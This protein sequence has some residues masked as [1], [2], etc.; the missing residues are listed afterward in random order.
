MSNH[1]STN[2]W[3]E[4][5][6]TAL[7]KLEL[8]LAE[9][10]MKDITVLDVGPGGIAQRYASQIPS[11]D[12]YDMDIIARARKNTVNWPESIARDK[13]SSEL[14]SFEPREIY[15]LFSE[16]IGIREMIV[17]DREKRVIDAVNNMN[18]SHTRTLLRDIEDTNPHDMQADVVIGLVLIEYCKKN[19]IQARRSLYDSVK[20]GGF[21]LVNLP[22]NIP[23]YIPGFTQINV[24][25]RKPLRDIEDPRKIYVKRE[26]SANPTHI[27]FHAPKLDEQR[28]VYLAET[29]DLAARESI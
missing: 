20:P 12:Q 7:R 25:F 6:I 16:R 22:S 2:T 11:G 28:I 17:A 1:L 19:Q 4:R 9:R 5:N 3:P 26:N 24:P 29:A 14:V 13:L 23:D 21:L 15:N 18:I 8:I 27:Q 10:K